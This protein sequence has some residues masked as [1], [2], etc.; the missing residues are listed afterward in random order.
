[1]P[2][3]DITEQGNPLKYVGNEKKKVCLSH[4]LRKCVYTGFK[5]IV[6]VRT[7]VTN[8]NVLWTNSELFKEKDAVCK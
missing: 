8:A 5:L 7:C 3:N 2:P 6:D 1:M 4:A